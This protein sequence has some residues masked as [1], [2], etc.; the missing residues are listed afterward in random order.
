MRVIMRQDRVAI[1]PI[2]EARKGSLVLPCASVHLWLVEAT[3]P[4]ERSGALQPGDLVMVRPGADLSTCIVW[5][6][7]CVCY[8]R[9]GQIQALPGDVVVEC[10]R[11]E[12]QGVITQVHLR[13][14]VGGGKALGGEHQGSTVMLDIN[15]PMTV[16]DDRGRTL[17]VVSEDSLLAVLDDE[18]RFEVR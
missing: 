8:W 1:R 10:V 5:G 6:S 2:T 4:G 3:G 9:N 17:V 7:D 18:A 14:S 11:E 12:Y 13:R 15:A 16:L